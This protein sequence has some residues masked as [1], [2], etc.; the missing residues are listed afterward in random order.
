[1]RQRLQQQ[2]RF[3]AACL[4]MILA[5][6]KIVEAHSEGGAATGFFSGFKHPISGLGSRVSIMFQACYGAKFALSKLTGRGW[7]K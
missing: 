6:T 7:H 5:T 2:S 4:L 1:M 3:V